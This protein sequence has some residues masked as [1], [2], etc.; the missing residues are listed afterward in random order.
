[1]AAGE[2]PVL[3]KYRDRMDKAFAALAA[4]SDPVST[5]AP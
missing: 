3:S 1:M 4:I 5:T 2:K